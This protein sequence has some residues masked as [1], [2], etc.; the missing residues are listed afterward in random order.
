M[1][2]ELL[3]NSIGYLRLDKFVDSRKS[4][5]SYRDAIRQAKDTKAL[6]IDMRYNSGGSPDA[7][8][9]LFGLLADLGDEKLF[10]IA[11]R[12]YHYYISGDDSNNKIISSDLPIY[13]LTSS[14]TASAA[15]AFIFLLR[16]KGLALSVGEKTYGAGNL[17]T[18]YEV[19]RDFD[20]LLPTSLVVHY[21]T[22]E[23]WE[24][25]GI[26]PSISV[27]AEKA[28]QRA[29]QHIMSAEY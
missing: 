5:L 24:K 14:K 22:G 16:N 1:Q 27:I 8:V 10:E 13:V 23:S 3:D 15:E 29:K 11:G 25:N 9:S 20:L 26:A 12:D 21:E 6:I 19:D 2:F 28:L 18:T 7:V 17:G 4:L